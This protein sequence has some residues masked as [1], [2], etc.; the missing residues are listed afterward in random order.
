MKQGR[1]ILVTLSLLLCFTGIMAQPDLSRR[2]S[3]HMDDTSIEQVLQIIEHETGTR[4]SYSHKRIRADRHISLHVDDLKVSS[5]LDTLCRKTGLE[6]LVVES[7]IVLKTARRTSSLLPAGPFHYTLSGYIRDL[8]T[9]EALIGATV[10]VAALEKGTVSN[11][12][13]Y[14]SLTLPKGS[15][16]TTVIEQLFS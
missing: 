5:V 11:E 1:R 16:A 2:I 9:N 13:G 15:Y 12:F 6:Y 3:L 4:F 7:H 10:Y 14:Y 8:S